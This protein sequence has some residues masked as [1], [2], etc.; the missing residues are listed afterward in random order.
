MRD[1]FRHGIALQPFGAAFAAVAAFLDAA[2]RRFGDGGDE[3]IDGKVSDFNLGCGMN[4]IADFVL[5][6]GLKLIEKFLHRVHH[7]RISRLVTG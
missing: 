2:E 4:V 6:T 5:L 3:M 1:V 7:A